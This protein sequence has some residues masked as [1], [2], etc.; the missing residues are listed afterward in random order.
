MP[1]SRFHLVVIFLA[2]VQNS[3]EPRPVMSP[4]RLKLLPPLPN[5]SLIAPPN[6]PVRSMSAA[7]LIAVEAAL[8]RFGQVMIHAAGLTLPNANALILIHAPSG[9]GKTTAALTL[10][11]HGFGLCAD[12]A[13]VAQ[14][15][16]DGGVTAWG[17]PRAPR[18]HRNTVA[19]L[20]WL[21]AVVRHDWDAGGEQL[22]Q[23]R[24]LQKVVAV[25]QA[26][27]RP[28]AALFRLRRVGGHEASTARLKPTEA[29]LNLTEDNVRPSPGALLPLQQRRF[30]I[31]ARLASMVP[32]FDLHMGSDLRAL[33]PAILRAL[34]EPL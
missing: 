24:S 27:P 5:A 12:D 21:R 19:M 13:I 23:L 10:A 28:L 22:V 26:A 17:F 6:A 7:A 33:R 14:R 8:D 29:L 18:I 3:I 34:D 30:A 1:A 32:A 2:W 9:T 11:Y 4:R 16:A 15:S 20:P 31:L 25:K